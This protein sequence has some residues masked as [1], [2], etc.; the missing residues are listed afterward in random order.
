VCDWVS[1]ETKRIHIAVS[2]KDNIDDDDDRIDPLVHF[3]PMRI[4]RLIWRTVGRHKAKLIVAALDKLEREASA[5][6]IIA[7]SVETG[8]HDDA[9][10]ADGSR[11]GTC[12]DDPQ[13]MI[14][15]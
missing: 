6:E 13:K 14:G 7:M 5:S 2:L 11:R 9:S 12:I 3:T 15:E 4:A 8:D 1:I 10:P